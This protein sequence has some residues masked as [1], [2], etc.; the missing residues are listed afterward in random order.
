MATRTALFGI[1]RRG[2]G[3]TFRTVPPHRVAAQIAAF[4]HA[5]SRDRSDVKFPERRIA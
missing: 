4:A 3:R 2:N 5:A 1:V